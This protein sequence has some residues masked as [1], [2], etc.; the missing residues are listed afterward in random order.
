MRKRELAGLVGLVVFAVQGCGGGAGDYLFQE[1][2]AQSSGGMPAS[3]GGSA[4][5]TAAGTS[6]AGTSGSSSIAGSSTGGSSAGSFGSGGAAG[7]AGSAGSAGSAGLA[8]TSGAGGMVPRCENPVEV[9]NTDDNQFVLDTF[10]AICIRITEEDIMGGWNC[11][12]IE[13]RTIAV[14]DVVVECEAWPLPP[15]GEAYLFAFSAGEHDYAS[16]Q[17]W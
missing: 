12:N 11:S 5:M 1:G 7:G 16:I 2:I 10:D 8:G 4:G 13:G 15:K 14:N 6:G 3:T 9:D 17:W